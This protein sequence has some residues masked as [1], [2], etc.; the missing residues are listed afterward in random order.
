MLFENYALFIPFTVLVEPYFNRNTT[1]KN[2]PK[3]INFTLET[4]KD[5]L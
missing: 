4:A 1:S 5:F 2:S 3:S